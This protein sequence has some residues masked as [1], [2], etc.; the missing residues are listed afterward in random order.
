MTEEEMLEWERSEAE[1]KKKQEE[2]K[3]ERQRF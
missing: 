1:S 2:E 3:K